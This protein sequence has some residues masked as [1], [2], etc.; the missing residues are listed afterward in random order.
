M[1]TEIINISPAKKIDTF[2]TVTITVEAVNDSDQPIVMDH[3]SVGIF[4]E[5]RSQED[6]V[7]LVMDEALRVKMLYSDRLQEPPEVHTIAPGERLELVFDLA[8]YYYPFCQGIYRIVPCFYSVETDKQQGEAVELEVQSVGACQILQWYE[9]PIFGTESLLCST[10]GANGDARCYLRWLGMNR[11][12]GAFF[13]KRLEAAGPERCAIA[14][15][16]AF[17]DPDYMQAGFEKIIVW[18]DGENHITVT[19]Y[20][21]GD[22]KGQP[23]AVELPDASAVLPYSFHTIAG[24]LFVFTCKEESDSRVV[25]GYIIDLWGDQ[26]VIG[27]LEHRVS[28]PGPVAI[29]GGPDI[30]HLISGGKNLTHVMFNLMG[31]HVQ[32]NQIAQV[33]GEPYDLFVNLISNQI[34]VVYLDP[35]QRGGVILVQSSF[36]SLEEPEVE[37]RIEKLRLAVP[38]EGQVQEIVFLFDSTEAHV[39]YSTKDGRL[40]YRGAGGRFRRLAAG[41]TRY[42]PKIMPGETDDWEPPFLGYFSSSNGY[43]FYPTFGTNPWQTIREIKI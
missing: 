22:L 23:V 6:E 32:T 21:N 9:N 10:A 42:F 38:R 43:R 36:P 34:K 1:Q 7:L 29:C 13:N 31:E 19:I 2:T 39:L 37:A 17:F 4:L 33:E 28:E 11:P 27:C 18:P 16:P 14:S 3:D 26:S 5:V 12:M 30:I 8:N 40:I 15:I 20:E 41:E 35:S 25:K 24:M